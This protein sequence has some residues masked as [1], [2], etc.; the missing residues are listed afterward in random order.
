MRAAEA[1]DLA[2]KIRRIEDY[3]S[4]KIVAQVGDT[5]VKLARIQGTFDWHTHEKE[6]E[7]F[8]VLDGRLKLEFR[9]GE[10]WIEPGQL[11]VVPHGVEHRPVA[12]E[13]VQIMLV[14]PAGTRNTGHR[15]T[16]RTVEAEWI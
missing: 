13:E 12:S 8:L 6:D 14:E 9:D 11:Y 15:T 3:W 16:D 4:P 2:E 1:I 5:E 7:L 10:V